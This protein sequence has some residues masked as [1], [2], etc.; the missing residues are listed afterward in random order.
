MKTKKLTDDFYWVGN[1]DP[2]LRVFD[3]VM[4]TEFGTTY[5]SYI[6]VGS[7]KVALF[8]AAKLKCFD[9]YIEKIKEIVPLEKIDYLI[10]NHTEPDH[11]GTIEKMLELMPNLKI[12]GSMGALNF[13]N[14]ITNKKIEGVMVKDNDT[15]SLGNYTLKFIS[16]PNLHWPDS[17]FTYIPEIKTLLTCDAFGSHY[18]DENITDD[19]LKSREDYIKALEYYFVNI[20]G[21][22]K[23]DMLS[24]IEKIKDLNIDILAV[25]HGPVIIK[26]VD[27]VISRYKD[28]A[29]DKSPFKNKTVVIPY[30]TS[31]GYTKMLAEEIEKGVKS[32]GVD[33]ISYDLVY[34]DLNKVMNDL[35]FADGI[36]FGTPTI[37][38]E[39]LPNIW[40]LAV[41]LNKHVHKGKLVSAFGSFG[42]SGEGVPNI[43]GRLNQLGTVSVFEE[44][45]KTRFKPSLN[46][47]AGAFEFGSR[48]AEE[49]KKK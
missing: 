31:Y 35:Y 6:L 32:Q 45:F 20:I 36:L 44:G 25:G 27:D 24:A 41:S 22:F 48:F 29:T 39:A 1:L 3:I 28:L 18:S 10:V 33:T 46:T 43:I 16:A 5:N 40:N 47:L 7:E 34:T 8:E 14:E 23:K 13:L 2:D 38:G 37:A 21:P 12:Y 9:E 26:H 15:L 30:V 19:N 11:T 42:W 4:E 49:L 17:I